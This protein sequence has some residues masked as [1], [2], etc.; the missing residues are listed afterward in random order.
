M[1]CCYEACGAS[2]TAGAVLDCFDLGS[3]EK[4]FVI[5][6]YASAVTIFGNSETTVQLGSGCTGNA[7]MVGEECFV[8]LVGKR[9]KARSMLAGSDR[10]QSSALSF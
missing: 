3:F 5:M 4:L 2:R 6:D 8:A 10:W 7:S 9:V 1:K